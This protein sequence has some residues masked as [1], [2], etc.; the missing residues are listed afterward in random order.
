MDLTEFLLA[1]IAEDEAAARAA[2]DPDRPGTHWHWVMDANDTPVRHG[3]L[4]RAQDDGESVSL[5]TV[6]EYPTRSGVGPLPHF[7][8]QS[9]DVHGIG[10]EHI[11][12]WDPARVLAECDAKRRIIELHAS[13]PVL[14]ETPPELTQSDSPTEMTFRLTQ[15]IAWTTQDEYRKRFGNEP[16]TAPMI[17]TLAL[18]YA[19][20][21]DYRQEWKVYGRSGVGL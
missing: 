7:V 10:G 18:P 13:W 11:A 8:V 5:R 6:E 2:I 4:Q 14:V 1:R 16:P 17:R 12:R 9:G 19:D 3:H 21:P 20:H 15:Q